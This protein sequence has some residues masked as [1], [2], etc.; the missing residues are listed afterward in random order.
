MKLWKF[1]LKPSDDNAVIYHDTDKYTLYA[2]TIN[3]AFA[4][5]FKEE[6]N[7]S[8]FK[9]KKSEITK[10]DWEEFSKV[11]GETILDQRYLATRN[12]HN[13]HAK[14]SEY[15]IP[16]LCTWFEYQ[17]VDSEFAQVY[18]MTPEW[19]DRMPPHVCFN[20]KIIR[21][22]KVLQYDGLF[23]LIAEKGHAF[24]SPNEDLPSPNVG[25][26]EFGLF[27]STFCSTF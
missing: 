1:W 8:R 13:K 5:Q 20:K 4:K 7:M 26:D 22:L 17:T 19:W 16:I 6:R 21:A 15:D 24:V 9:V 27:I 25:I 2:C 12:Y 18:A 14:G 11:N 10:E 3:K 23:E